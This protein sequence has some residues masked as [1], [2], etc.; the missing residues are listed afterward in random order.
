MAHA[1]RFVL[2][3]RADFRVIDAAVRREP[4]RRRDGVFTISVERVGGW[5]CHEPSPYARCLSQQDAVEP[6]L[7]IAPG[8]LVERFIAPRTRASRSPFRDDVK[9]LGPD[10]VFADGDA[11]RQF[12][13]IGV[14]G[15]RDGATGGGF[16]LGHFSGFLS[17]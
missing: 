13:E 1:Y 4:D 3:A 10:L 6:G 16:L 12:G 8:D 17:A 5:N 2:V 14:F 15:G 7:G 11:L 9:L